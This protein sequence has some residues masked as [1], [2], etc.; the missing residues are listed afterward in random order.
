MFSLANTAHFTLQIPTVRNDFKVLAF[1]GV[2]AISQLYAIRV[3]LVS[4]EPEM[5]LE[6]L[7]GLPGRLEPGRNLHVP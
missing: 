4:E 7:L 2:E 6:A 1:E 5:D 3:E